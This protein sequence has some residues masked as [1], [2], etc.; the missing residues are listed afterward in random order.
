M[1]RG[2]WLL[3]FTVLMACCYQ[4]VGVTMEDP[5]TLHSTIYQWLSVVRETRLGL[6]TQLISRNYRIG[7]DEKA[8]GSTM[9]S[10]WASEHKAI[11]FKAKMFSGIR[12]KRHINERITDAMN[13]GIEKP[14]KIKELLRLSLAEVIG[15]EGNG[16]VISRGDPKELT[17]QL[18]HPSHFNSP[19]NLNPFAF[20]RFQAFHPLLNP[21]AF[22]G[23]HNPYVL[24][25]DTSDRNRP[26]PLR[27]NLPLMAMIDPEEIRHP[28]SYTKY[29]PT[30]PHQTIT[31][32]NGVLSLWFPGLVGAA[33]PNRI[34]HCCTDGVTQDVVD[35]LEIANMG[36][37]HPSIHADD[38]KYAIKALNDMAFT[39]P[40][41]SQ[42]GL[43][44]P[45]YIRQYARR[46][47]CQMIVGGHISMRVML[48]GGYRVSRVKAHTKN[49]NIDKARIKPDSVPLKAVEIFVNEQVEYAK[50]NRDED[51]HRW[52]YRL[53]DS[54]TD[55]DDDFIEKSVD[56]LRKEH[57]LSFW[58]LSRAV[59]Y[60]V[61]GL[62]EERIQLKFFTAFLEHSGCVAI[63]DAFRN[64]PANGLLGYVDDPLLPGDIVEAR[65]HSHPGKINRL[66][67]SPADGP[68]TTGHI[69]E[70]KQ[71]LMRI[72]IAG[73]KSKQDYWAPLGC[74][75]V[76]VVGYCESHGIR[77]EGFT[78]LEFRKAKVQGKACGFNARSSVPIK[79]LLS[80]FQYD[81]AMFH[82]QGN[83][84][85]RVDLNSRVN[86]DQSG[87][88][89]I[90]LP[91]P[92]E[93]VQRVFLSDRIGADELLDSGTSD[94]ERLTLK[95]F[96]SAMQVLGASFFH[97][98][99]FS[100][101]QPLMDR[102]AIRHILTHLGNGAPEFDLVMSE[103]DVD[104]I[105][106]HYDHS[107]NGQ[108]GMDE[109]IAFIL[110]VKDGYE[111]RDGWG[112]C[113]VCRTL[114]IAPKKQRMKSLTYTFQDSEVP[115][116][117]FYHAL[118]VLID[119][120]N[121]RF[122]KERI[123]GNGIKH[124]AKMHSK[125][126]LVNDMMALDLTS[127]LNKLDR[128][129]LV[130]SAYLRILERTYTTLPVSENG[131]DIISRIDN[132][133]IGIRE[134]A[135]LWRLT[136]VKM[137][138]N[139]SLLKRH[140]LAASGF[141]LFTDDLL[142]FRLVRDAILLIYRNLLVRSQL[143]LEVGGPYAEVVLKHSMFGKSGTKDALRFI[144]QS[145]NYLDVND[146][147]L[148]RERL[149][150]TLMSVTAQNWQVGQY[151]ALNSF[152][153]FTLMTDLSILRMEIAEWYLT[154]LRKHF[155]GIA[156]TL[157]DQLTYYSM[158][159]K[160]KSLH[161]QLLF[162]I[163]SYANLQILDAGIYRSLMSLRYVDGAYRHLFVLS[164][165]NSA[166]KK[167]GDDDV[168]SINRVAKLVE[169]AEFCDLMATFYEYESSGPKFD[170]AFLTSTLLPNMRL[171]ANKWNY[172]YTELARI[173]NG[174][175][176]LG[177]FDTISYGSFGV[178]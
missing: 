99:Y 70:L 149:E 110:E 152:L 164:I 97:F 59:S 90:Y 41:P 116:S 136:R 102:E 167:K 93:L 60:E 3:G 120:M 138:D 18:L 140:F 96:L 72:H 100:K 43:K 24:T 178:Q 124:T 33:F 26:F 161:L 137:I 106:K 68:W 108:F 113:D 40:W 79:A 54:T 6:S 107:K 25:N 12:K 56:K 77:M 105:I 139:A 14:K 169:S 155:S 115:E 94:D 73:T 28:T 15:T 156:F 61:L 91:F 88:G 83:I 157:D 87:A 175:N 109:F 2:L 103:K 62:D 75:Y 133:L 74:D 154:I 67:T 101:G 11:R 29:R 66:A 151:R 150:A 114:S 55:E 34:P 117:K 162:R 176:E 118:E 121:V 48:S 27:R 127:Y 160:Y 51:W 23:W 42:K 81:E 47:N 128:Y 170:S 45:K 10:Y 92:Q 159:A 119:G 13:S 31:G 7:F 126:M 20:D 86:K 172:L 134:R 30:L 64:A 9:L 38:A 19:M 173:K 158:Y 50:Q 17:H 165:I 166:Y 95:G 53:P 84:N 63:G 132:A 85:N 4:T 57:G 142:S 168:V 146:I 131:G 80:D 125:Y 153:F 144:K 16:S 21:H 89:V 39:T 123:I 147:R 36:G 1:Q 76:K 71:N 111:Q 141:A 78:N 171:E 46:E 69:V 52:T 148:F 129:E 104:K 65:M 49:P 177:R 112:T 143:T 58:V 5:Q 122:S 145:L 135:L 82:E 44:L 22:M 130:L 37:I 98:S 32:R 163:V 174:Y 35:G 8:H